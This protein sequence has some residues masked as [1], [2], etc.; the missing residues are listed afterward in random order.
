[1]VLPPGNLEARLL[2]IFMKSIGGVSVEPRG[3]CD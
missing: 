3:F 2:F 1:M